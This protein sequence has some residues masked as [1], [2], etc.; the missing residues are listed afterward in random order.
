[1]GVQTGLLHIGT[2][3]ELETALGMLLSARETLGRGFSTGEN[4]ERK[5]R[6]KTG[7]SQVVLMFDG[8]CEPYNPGGIATYGF[9]VYQDGMKIYEEGGIVG[10]GIL[11]D[12]VSNNV[13]EYTALIKGMEHIIESGYRGPLIVRGDSQLVIR[14]ML[15]EYA[16]RARRLTGLHERA[17]QLVQHFERVAFEWVPREENADADRLCRAAYENLIRKMREAMGE[18]IKK[19]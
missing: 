4:K 16:A 11:G 7:G 10:A 2:I 5:A 9:V 8:L 13:A 19:V 1:M 17:K 6:P 3:T 14:Q 12:D 15:G 18:K